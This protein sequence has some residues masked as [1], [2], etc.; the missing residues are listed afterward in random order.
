M[1]KTKPIFGKTSIE[2][3]RKGIDTV[4][5]AVSPT[6][7]GAG[8]N[9]IYRSIY[10]RAPMVTNDGVSIARMIDLE[11]ETEAIGADLI[12]QSAARTNDEA[13]DGTTTAV[14]LSKSMVDKG[15]EVIKRGKNPMLLNKEIQA[16][17]KKVCQKIKDISIP[18]KTDED[19]FHIANISMENPEIAHIVADSVKKVGENG[20]VFVEE[21]NGLTIEKEEIEG[22]KFDKGYIAPF[23]ANKISTMETVLNDV[24]VLVTNKQMSVNQDIIGLWNNIAARQI[25]QLL[26]ICD[27]VTGELLSTIFQNRMQDVFNLVVVS[28]PIDDDVL[29]DIVSFTGAD[30]L[31]QDKIPGAFKE[32]HF[33]FLGKVK[34]AIIT[35]DSTLLIGGYGDEK[36]VKERVDSIK[37]EIKTASGFVKE[38]LTERLA[39]L[40]G[41]V[42]ILKVGA[43]TEAEMKYLKLKIDDAVGSTRAALAEGIVIGGGKALYEIGLEKPLNEGEEVVYYACQQPFKKILTNAGLN[44]KSIIGRFWQKGIQK[45]EV[46]DVN[47]GQII[48]DPIKEGLIDPAKVERCAVTN[49]ASLASTVVTTHTTIIDI[50]KKS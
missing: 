43:P 3:L 19:I 4:Y 29:S 40:V 39:N 46:F 37:E 10:S 2:G 27:S 16:A 48:K 45:G 38:K 34:K 7:G 47:K 14:V 23:M 36:V 32:E 33:K 1:D 9:V 50:P 6:L 17:A 15:F 35:K 21:S 49:A 42:I 13:G 30:Y 18:I 44:P 25:K 5:E 22:L 28:K 8:K 11:D 20:T 31:S 24:L 41:K 26:V 12:K